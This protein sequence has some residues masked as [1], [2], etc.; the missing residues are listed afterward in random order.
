[1]ASKQRPAGRWTARWKAGD[2]TVPSPQRRAEP[3]AIGTTVSAPNEVWRNTLVG[4]VARDM[5]VRDPST[6]DRVAD[7]IDTALSLLYVDAA[8]C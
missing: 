4:R 5:G 6:F 8:R 1:M 7:A 2:A 3:V